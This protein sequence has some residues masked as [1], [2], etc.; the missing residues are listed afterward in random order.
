MLDALREYAVGH[1]T[2]PFTSYLYNR[3]H[4]MSRYRRFVKSELY[5]EE[6]L[7][8]I[9]LKGL[10]QLIDYAARYVPYY[11]RVFRDI[12]LQPQ[13]IKTLDDL[14][15]IPPLS[16]QDVIEHS[17]DMVDTRFQSSISVA[18]RSSKGPGEPLPFAIFRKHKLVR[19]T[20]SGSTGAPT[21]F[22]ED[23]SQ[24]ALSWAHEMRLKSWYQ[25]PALAKEARLVKVSTVYK[26]D[27]V[28]R[29]RN[30]LWNQLILP[31]VNLGEKEY[32]LCFSQIMK[33]R[34]RVLWGFTPALAGFAQY[35]EEARKPMLSYHPDL[36][37]GWASPLYDHEARILKQVFRCAV[38]NIY[39][40]REVGHVAGLCPS[41]TFHVNQE[42]IVVETESLPSVLGQ[43]AG[44]MLV[45]TLHRTPM[46]FIRYR[47][48]DLG[49]VGPSS[50]AC[51]RKLQVVKNLLG[52]TGE[53]FIAKDGRMYSPNFWCRTFM[54]VEHAK[55]IRRFQVIYTKEQNL[56]ILVQKG[57]GYTAD[58][59]KYIETMVNSNF[60]PDTE[61]EL[62]YVP[63]IKAHL[64]GKY[65][66][67]F[68][69]T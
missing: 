50:C 40:A 53:I 59:E 16:R 54:S 37:V 57:P 49:E 12:S 14:K 21:M 45:T 52:R 32:E 38:S 6:A 13:D 31:G 28:A 3:R 68:N 66:M 64:S 4:I 46:P 30:L 29:F 58:T 27:R 7:R 39:G 1:L 22:Y 33:H 60:S 62:V 42:N 34:P 65:Q 23:G 10:A 36:V 9:Q 67:V 61:L 2:F 56:R 43:A 41:G 48:G 20:S 19:N 35:I 69:E 51:G 17:H 63:E 26:Y 44:E 8:D 24:T 5:P 11:Q 25:V 18:D 47:M 15:L 55:N